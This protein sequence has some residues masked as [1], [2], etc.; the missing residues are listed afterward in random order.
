LRE[1]NAKESTGV[2]LAIVKKIVED[3]HCTVKVNSKLD[4][5][6][7]FIFTWPKN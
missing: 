1:K 4:Q 6:A 5:G 2:G 7:S 3:R